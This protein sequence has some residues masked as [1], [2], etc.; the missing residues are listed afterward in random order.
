MKISA[1]AVLM[2]LSASLFAQS[3][4]KKQVQIGLLLDVRNSEVEPLI[5]RLKNEIIAVVGEDAEIILNED[6][7]LVNG[8]NLQ[9][10]EQNYQQV[11]NGNSDI[12][13]AFGAINNV[14][15]S[16]QT[17]HN[18]PTIL[19]G[20][21]PGDFAELDKT[22]SSSGIPNLAYLITSQSFLVDLEAFSQLYNYK[23]VAIAMEKPVVENLEVKAL[24]DGAFD[25]KS[26]TYQLISFESVDDIIAGLEGA[27]ALYMGGGFILPG[28]EIQR[29]ADVLLEKGIPSFTA[30]SAEDVEL[31]LM[32]TNQSR[33]NLEQLFR[34]IALGVEAINNGVNAGDLPLYIEG[35][36]VLTV[37]FNTAERLGVPIK[38][39]LIASTNFVGDF[40]N[41]VAEQRYTLRDIMNEALGENLSLQASAKDIDL[42]GQ[43]LK[44]AKSNYLPDVTA[45]AT[46]SY[47]DP[48]L[49]EV[50]N[51][52]NPEFSTAGNVSLQQVIYSPSVSANVKIQ[53]ALQKAQQASYNA[54]Q[55]NTL[56]DA[57]NA[58]FNALLLKANLE[59]T[60]RNLE[61]TKRNLQIA[62]QNYE[63][64]QSG[65]SDVLRFRSE[66]AQNTQSLV[67]AINQ[68]EQAFLSINQLLN[69]PIT[70]DIDVA[71]AELGQGIF[72]EYDYSELRDFLDN[73]SL[74][75]PF[76]GFLV[77]QAK[78]NAPELKNLAYNLEAVDQ[79]LKLATNGR[80]IPTL[81]LQ[82][83]YNYTF[84]RSGAGS[85][86]PMGF[87][88]IPD[89]YYSMGLNLSLP[90]FNQNKQNINRQ[91]ATIQK[92]QI[93]LNRDNV[94]LN[95]E[96]NVNVAVL[97]MINQITNIELSKVS[98][99]AARESLEL[100]QEAY[101]RGSVNWVELI[102]S[103][104]NYQNA[105]LANASAVYNYLLSALQLERYL[106]QYFLL[107]TTEQNR[108]FRQEFFN[109]LL[110]Q[111]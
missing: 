7:I 86:V 64:G 3:T 88:N 74:R 100:T 89:G 91:T 41:S 39:S 4:A 52:Q 61:V 84:N 109:Y 29:L 32:A 81:A 76:V 6:D 15:V 13:L 73:P 96:R 75:E 51:G 9:Q 38:Y 35:S 34:R 36:Q 63:S 67:E 71:D 42:V 27:D 46:G 16:K 87:G 105:Q 102:D 11:I 101:E 59:I 95:L 85:E 97:Q 1:I 48:A 83:Q 98:A 66:M 50:S 31:G 62:Q 18:K 54:D 21:V 43:D 12:I 25:Q 99:D 28:S 33:Q 110:T 26:A 94:S 19:F 82:G 8:F 49:A 20:S 69:Q 14:V 79:N 104:T 77:D 56:F 70:R 58:Y 44:T 92:E 60:A 65:K 40:E 2:L 93:N 47:L 5:G 22:R 107:N 17:E 23:N 24:L 78:K 103:Q 45:S 106:G 37:N 90:I 108:A 111:N 57:A 30:T 72:T 80:F 10:A 53:G 55:L 68:L